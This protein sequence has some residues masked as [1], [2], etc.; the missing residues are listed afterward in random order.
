M[1]SQQLIKELKT[2][3]KE[4]Y[5]KDLGAEEV[6]QIANNLVGYFD[7]LAQINYRESTESIPP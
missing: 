1:V 4:E 5:G 3:L 2:I 7:L 6:A